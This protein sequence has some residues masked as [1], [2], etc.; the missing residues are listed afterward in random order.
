M[1]TS[2]IITLCYLRS[3][4]IELLCRSSGYGCG[5][6][7]LS[8]ANGMPHFNTGN[9]AAGRPKGLESQHRAYLSFHRTVILFNEIVEIFTLADED[10]GVVVA[11]VVLNGP[12]IRPA[13][14]D[15]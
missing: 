13:L 10:R 12:S 8:L 1:R 7:Q 2:E 14:V 3:Q 9:R 4:G 5:G 11:V 6:F 15:G